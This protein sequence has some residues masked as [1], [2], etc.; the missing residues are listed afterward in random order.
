MSA[1]P[2]VRD[3][4]VL[5]PVL[6]HDFQFTTLENSLTIS[7][8]CTT[9][10]LTLMMDSGFCIMQSYQSSHITLK[11]GRSFLAHSFIVY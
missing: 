5:R 1:S 11:A 3:N 2:F 6:T 8:S 9:V 4:H 10:T 7:A